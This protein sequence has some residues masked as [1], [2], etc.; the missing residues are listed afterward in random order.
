VFRRF[1]IRRRVQAELRDEAAVLAPRLAHLRERLG[2]AQHRAY[3]EMEL[4]SEVPP[5]CPK[6][7]ETLRVRVAKKTSYNGAS[8]WGCPYYLTCRQGPIPLAEFPLA[9]YA[10]VTRTKKAKA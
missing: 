9:A 8:F 6:C 4:L 7:G 2:H 3:K 5:R 10:A 1:R